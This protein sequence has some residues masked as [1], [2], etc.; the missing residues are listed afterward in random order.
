MPVSN[1]KGTRLLIN[2]V[3]LWQSVIKNQPPFLAGAVLL[4]L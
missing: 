1:K 4:W 2:I 3:M